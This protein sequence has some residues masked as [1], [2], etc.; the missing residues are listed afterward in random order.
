MIVKIIPASAAKALMTFMVVT[1]SP[2]NRVLKHSK[3]K[4]NQT[5]KTLKEIFSAV[6]F[7]DVSQG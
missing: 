2:W 6:P 1:R 4:L 5:Q 7:P 3:E